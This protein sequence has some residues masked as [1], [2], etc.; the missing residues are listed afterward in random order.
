M[1]YLILCFICIALLACL[2]AGSIFGLL[3]YNIKPLAFVIGMAGF[4]LFYMAQS[5]GE[6]HNLSLRMAKMIVRMV[7]FVVHLF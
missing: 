2:A 3:R 5:D 6:I 4:A 1:T 7:Q